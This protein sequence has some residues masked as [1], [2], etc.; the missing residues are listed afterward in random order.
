L[1]ARLGRD[2]FAA[3]SIWRNIR[4]AGRAAT[5]PFVAIAL[6][7]WFGLNLVQGDR[8][9]LAWAKLAREV[10]AAEATL[11]AT[12]AEK[13][14][15]DHRIGLLKADHLD[16]DMLDERARA[17]LNLIGPDEVVIFPPPEKQ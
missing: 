5:G 1:T 4:K 3:V 15:L 16:P 17:T 6:I 7:V 9:L 10:R 11:A 8:G 2:S 14:R 13:G 12:E